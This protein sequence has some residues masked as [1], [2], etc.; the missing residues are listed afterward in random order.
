[1]PYARITDIVTRE[2]RTPGEL[3]RERRTRMRRE[4]QPRL[5]Q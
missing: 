3:N 1:M 2:T 5:F 4:K